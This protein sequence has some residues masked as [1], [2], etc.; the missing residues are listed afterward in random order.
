MWPHYSFPLPEEMAST[1]CHCQVPSTSL[2]YSLMLYIIYN[3]MYDTTKILQKYTTT[4]KILT[5]S[6]K[7][8]NYELYYNYKCSNDRTNSPKNT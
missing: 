5:I 6:A 3:Y 7:H 2:H 4:L 1:S 8:N